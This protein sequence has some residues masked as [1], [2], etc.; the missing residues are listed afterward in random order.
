MLKTKH[1]YFEKLCV[2]VEAVVAESNADNVSALVEEAERERESLFSNSEPNNFLLAIKIAR[3]VAFAPKLSAPEAAIKV[4]LDVSFAM[5]VR[6][7]GCSA[8]LLAERCVDL[9]KEHALMPELRRALSVCGAHNTD[10]GFYSRGLEYA[11]RSIA[12]AHQLNEAKGIVV[13]NVNL[14][15]ALSS[16]GLHR[17]CIEVVSRLQMKYGGDPRFRLEIAAAQVNTV[18]AFLVLQRYENA[19]QAATLALELCGSARNNDDMFVQLVCESALLKCSVAVDDDPAALNHLKTLLRLVE[20]INT[21]RSKLNGCL[22]KATYAIYAGGAASVLPEILNLLDVSIAM[23]TLYRDNLDLLIQAHKKLGDYPGALRY[24]SKLVDHQSKCQ[25][26][27]LKRAL[28]ALEVKVQTPV[29]G[30]D[31]VREVLTAIQTGDSSSR[32]K[33]VEIPPTQIWETYE[34]FALTAELREDASGRHMY[35]VGKLAKRLSKA[36]GHAEAMTEL[37]E[38]AAR[39]HDIGKLGLPDEVIMNAG[40]FSPEQY[41]AMQKHCEIGVRMI[42]QTNHSALNLAREV[43]QSHHERWDGTG[44]PQKLMGEAIPLSARIT[45]LAETYDVLTHG[46]TYRP[47]RTHSEAVSIIQNGAG[48]QFDPALVQVFVKLVNELHEKY[49]DDLPEFLAEAANESSFLQ[50]K[51]EMDRLIDTL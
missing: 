49:G 5:S 50:A 19:K 13:A 33:N 32:N 43:T 17:E 48:N 15:V 18:P 30:R 11:T 4:V 44:Y 29:P 34:T 26:D 12:V 40:K 2:L 20:D 10:L 7:P 8:L 38:H 21:P 46:R 25:L 24:L 41:Q 27:N 9:A 3:L 14:A 16:M 37:I 28:D 45:A 6:S 39:L 51:D 35:R 42:D 22:A 1:N 23:P 47:A 36:L 31:D